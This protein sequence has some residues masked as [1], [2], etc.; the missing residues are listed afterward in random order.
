MRRRRGRFRWAESRRVCRRGRRNGN[1]RPLFVSHKV[2][3]VGWWLFSLLLAKARGGIDL[4]NGDLRGGLLLRRAGAAIY[5]EIK[6]SIAMIMARA[7][8]WADMPL[9]VISGPRS[10]ISHRRART[11]SR[12][13]LKRQ[14]SSVS[15]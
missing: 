9:R 3:A 15:C 8:T 12:L 14:S 10:A 1:A 11:W 5:Q 13:W 4:R 2:R 6:P 7:L